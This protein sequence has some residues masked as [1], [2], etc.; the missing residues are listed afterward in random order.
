VC[1]KMGAHDYS[2]VDFDD[3][4]YGFKEEDK[5]ELKVSSHFCNGG[6]LR[7]SFQAKNE[8]LLQD[9]VERCKGGVFGT[10][11]QAVDEIQIPRIKATRP[12]K[13]YDG[14]LNL[15]DPKNYEESA[16]SINV[17]RYL[18]TKI[19]RPPT[20]STVAV[21]AYVGGEA[22]QSTQTLGEMEGIEHTAPYGAVENDRTYR[23]EDPM[24]PGGK[25]DVPY[26]SLAKGYMYGRTAV[27]IS[28]SDRNITDLL[29]VQDFSIIGFVPNTKVSIAFVDMQ[30]YR[31]ER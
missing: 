27:Y 17:E 30:V 22:S 6:N 5:P 26:D 24:A 15:G 4:E 1:S 14:P 8:K 2:G 3:P 16:L 23:V 20:A 29:T 18:K 21:K 28:E 11:A 10:M 19:A 9:L 25:K 13:T 7:S 12:Y 31:G